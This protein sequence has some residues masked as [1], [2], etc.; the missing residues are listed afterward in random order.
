MTTRLALFRTTKFHERN[1]DELSVG[2]TSYVLSG[3]RHAAGFET[4]VAGRITP[5]G[6]VYGSYAWIPDARVDRA[7]STLGTRRSRARS[8][9]R[10]S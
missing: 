4:H 10:T 9:R 7:S 1:R 5:D 6:E 2:P 8:S 3:A